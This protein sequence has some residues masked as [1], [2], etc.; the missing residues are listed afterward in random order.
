VMKAFSKKYPN[1]R[2]LGMKRNSNFSI[3]DTI[4]MIIL[5]MIAIL[6]FVPFLTMFINATHD[7][8]SIVQKINIFPGTELINNL[9]DLQENADVLSAFKNSV[10][11]AVSVTVLTGY[12]GALAAYGLS[13]YSFKG[14]KYLYLIVLATMMIPYQM[15][16]IGY[17]D[18][19][20]NI[21]N[22]FKITGGLWAII[23]PGMANSSSVFLLK[24]YSDSVVPISI[25]ESA[26]IDGSSEFR[27]FNSIVLPILMPCIATVSILAFVFTWN[28]L[29]IP[30]VVLAP[31]NKTLPILIAEVRGNY[32][33]RIG[34]Q[35]VAICISVIPI[36]VAFSFFSKY[37]IS[38]ITE[39]A[40]KG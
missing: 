22:F 8:A 14:R 20:L 3:L 30:M 12:F 2:R 19:V 1:N 29:L 18:L 23:V 7:T 11:A 16:L 9:K 37:I 33:D 5:I 32:G 38:G 25:V 31:E 21:G 10:I 27:T 17:F 4:I 34:A 15:S 39:G 40:I 36:L 24:L 28:N 13:K 26:R 6:C 35:Y